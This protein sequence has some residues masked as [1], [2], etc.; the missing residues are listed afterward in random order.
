MERP[1]KKIFMATVAAVVLVILV[2]VIC[3]YSGVF[4][5]GDPLDRKLN[6]ETYEQDLEQVLQGLSPDDR[7]ALLSGLMLSYYKKENVAGKT[8]RSFLETG[9]KMQGDYMEMVDRDMKD[10]LHRDSLQKDSLRRDSLT[11]QTKQ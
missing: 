10:F 3:V 4:S 9:R 7:T 1:N 11:R 8:Y 6:T 2:L 5:S